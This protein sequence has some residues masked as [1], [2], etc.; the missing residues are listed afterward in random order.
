MKGNSEV[1]DYLNFLISGELAARDQ[2]FIHARM[3][4]DWGYDKLFQAN[5]HEMGEEKP[6]MPRR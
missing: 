3:Y 2:Y 6:T 5:H 1:I 4:E